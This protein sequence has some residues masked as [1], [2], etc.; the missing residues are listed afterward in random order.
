GGDLDQGGHFAAVLAVDGDAGG[1]E[2]AGGAADLVAAAGG[3]AVIALG[4]FH[5][6]K[7]LVPPGLIDDRVLRQRDGVE[8]ELLELDGVGLVGLDLVAV[9]LDVGHF[10]LGAVPGELERAAVV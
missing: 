8:D 7:F 3:G 9:G 10:L 5:G 2:P 6:E 4:V 1:F